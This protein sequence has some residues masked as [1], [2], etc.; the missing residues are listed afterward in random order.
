MSEYEKAS[1]F[2]DFLNTSNFVFSNFMT[3]VFA[4]VAASFLI[5]HRMNRI[6][7]ALFLALYTMGAFWTGFGVFAA[8]TDFSSLGV[9]IHETAPPDGGD[10][11]W[12]GPVGP[13]GKDMGA[14]PLAIGVLTALAY[15]GSLV[16]FILVRKRKLE[17]D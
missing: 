7:A 13:F 9:F 16:F 1:L 17:G 3:L 8:F 6:T 5:A 11:R 14:M 4:M 10:L 2:V 12:L 15:I